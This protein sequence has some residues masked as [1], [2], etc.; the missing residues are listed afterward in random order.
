MKNYW[1]LNRKAVFQIQPSGSGHDL[2]VTFQFVFIEK[3][4]QF[5]LECFLQLLLLAVSWNLE[6]YFWGRDNF[7][8]IFF[9]R[10]QY[11]PL[12]NV[13]FEP[14]KYDQMTQKWYYQCTCVPGKNTHLKIWETCRVYICS[15]YILKPAMTTGKNLRKALLFIYRLH[16]WKKWNRVN[17]PNRN[18]YTVCLILYI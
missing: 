17:Q 8:R 7:W 12:G 2:H 16:F 10:L 11:I 4:S 6:F 13:F 15:K 3:W 18:S 14:L 5:Q 9:R 1:P